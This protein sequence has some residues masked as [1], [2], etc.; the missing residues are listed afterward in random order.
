M[1][2][3]SFHYQTLKIV[4]VFYP[5]CSTQSS[6]FDGPKETFRDAFLPGRDSNPLV[7]DPLVSLG[8]SGCYPYD[9]RSC[10]WRGGM[11]SRSPSGGGPPHRGLVVYFPFVETSFWL[12]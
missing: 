8:E 2:F 5:L 7:L 1:H 4:F 3:S 6:D 12:S 9:G 10:Q 11:P